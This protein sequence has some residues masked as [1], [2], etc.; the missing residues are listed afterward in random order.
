MLVFLAFQVHI[1]ADVT[2]RLLPLPAR[3]WTE[4]LDE[5]SYVCRSLLLCSH[6]C[7]RDYLRPLGYRKKAY[8]IHSCFASV[9]QAIHPLFLFLYAFFTCIDNT[10]YGIC[11]DRASI[12]SLTCISKIGVLLFKERCLLFR[13]VEILGIHAALFF[14]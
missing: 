4:N 12:S 9:F 8:I 10:K 1:L 2:S 14:F 7:L 6:I 5:P 3:D 13:C 11:R